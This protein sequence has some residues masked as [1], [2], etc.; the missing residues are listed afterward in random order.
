M[1]KCILLYHPGGRV[2]ERDSS[3]WME[4]PEHTDPPIP[5]YTDPP[6]PEHTDPL[7]WLVA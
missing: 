3:G 7:R 2:A 4:I 5:E 6:V 1:P